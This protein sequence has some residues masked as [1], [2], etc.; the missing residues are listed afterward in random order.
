VSILD[1]KL[2]PIALKQ[3][4]VITLKDVIANGG[5][6][7][8]A[9]E[10]CAGGRWE[11]VYPGVYRLAGV[12]WTYE[13]R[14]LAAVLA[15]GEGAVASHFCACRLQGVGFGTAGVEITVPRG[16]RCFLNNVKVHTST[17]LHLSTPYLAKDIPATDPDRT[18]LDIGRR[19]GPQMHR[20][21]VEDARRADLVD[22]P[23]LIRCLA[24]HA[25]PGRPG[26]RKL[27]ALIAVGATNDQVTDTDSELAALS[28]F[29]EHGFPEP[30][31]QHRI[32]SH[33]GKLEAE[34][35]FAYLDRLVNFEINGTVH[36]DPEQMK[37]DE[38][39]DYWLERL[40]WKVRRIWW[41]IP[42]FQPEEFIRIVR[43]TLNDRPVIIGS[44]LSDE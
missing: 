37:K 13:A 12:P 29:R 4:A 20:K 43:E 27:R 26:V 30:V 3:H 22:W 25:R 15:A 28:L 38:K 39:R 36:L 11:F 18:M 9:H 35:D 40:G 1:E 24:A 8:A 33:D 2:A 17:D 32:Y 21:A 10:R 44:G 7:H 34:M 31:L 16:R 19:L 23:S 41:E 5:N 42:V 6:K 14:V